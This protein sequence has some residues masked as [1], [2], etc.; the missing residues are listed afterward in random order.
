MIN[1]ILQVLLFQTV[2]LAV[3]DL[4]LKKETF[5]QW[6][7]AYL[8]IT[9]VLAYIIPLIRFTGASESIPQEYRIMLPEVMLSPETFIEKQVESSATI[10][11]GMQ[12]IF[13][14]GVTIASL[15]FVYK[16]FQIFKL[17][18][19]NSK[20][21]N[22]DY[23]L[24]LLSNQHTAFSFFHYIFLGK[25]THQKEEIIQHELIHVK[26]KHSIDLLFFELQKILLWFNPY[27][28]LYQ[29]RIAEIHEFIADA[30]TVNKKEKS[31]FYN[32]L[33]AETFHV[34]KLAFVNAFNKQS[35]IKKRIIMFSRKKSKEI[36]KF[37]YVLMIPVLMGMLLYTSCENTEPDR[38]L[39][40]VNEKRFIKFITEGYTKND[41]S[42]VEKRVVQ[43]EIEGYFDLYNG[44]N[45]GG[46]EISI[47]DLTDEEKAEYLKSILMHKD[48]S[49]KNLKIIEFENGNRMIQQIIDFRERDKYKNSK[50]YSNA[51]V[52]P[53][54]HID[55]VPIFP[56]CEDVKDQKACMVKKITEFVNSNFDT[57]LSKNLGLEPGKKRIYVQFKVD[58]DGEIV[59]VKARGPHTDLKEEA[60]RVVNSLPAMQAGEENGKKV[61]VKYTLPITLVVD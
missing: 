10:F 4:V 5:F 23:H 38:A 61:G 34:D 36:L 48:K 32:S 57:S 59:D 46:K 1:Y 35:I 40:K 19:Q 39:S 9:S 56:G 8:I 17:I 21:K 20:E 41:G 53:F 25:T 30:K 29:N 49:A 44:L 43:T 58:K 14:I 37:K 52:V 28:Y 2:F 50:D 31:T 18:H 54:A 47:S 26:Q 15:M 51:D 3:Y 22:K 6:N 13:I 11:S 27:S 45:P 16:L 55:Q 33:L 7:R 24:V 42:P 60:I 12:W